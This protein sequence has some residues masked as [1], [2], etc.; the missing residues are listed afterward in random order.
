MSQIDELLAA[1]QRFA[2]TFRPITDRRPRRHL[3]VLTC[4]DARI[5]VLEDFGLQLGD[6]AILRNAGGRVTDDV[7][8]SLA[9]SSHVLEVE[10][11]VVL[12]HTKCGLTGVSQDELEEVT[13]ASLSFLTIP[14]H[15]A[16]LRADVAL[17]AGTPFL[18]PITA[19]LGAVFNVDSGVIEEVVCWKRDE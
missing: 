11:V 6:A 4:M 18:S 7:L 13:G 12:Q 8:R 5:D 3:A 16:T 9:I 19:I 2:A 1:N 10:T 14:D 15:A 17:L